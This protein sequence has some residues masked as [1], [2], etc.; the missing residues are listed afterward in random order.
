MGKIDP[1]A[2]RLIGEGQ[3]GRQR[4]RRER[5]ILWLCVAVGVVLGLLIAPLAFHVVIHAL[6]PPNQARAWTRTDT[7]MSFGDSFSSLGIG[8]VETRKFD[9]DHW[10]EA[11]YVRLRALRPC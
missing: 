3:S 4:V 10:S 8:N 6:P 7:I 9:R 2:I 11:D 1:E 5:R